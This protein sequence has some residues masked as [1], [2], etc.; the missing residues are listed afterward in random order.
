MNRYKQSMRW[1]FLSLAVLPQ[2]H[3]IDAVNV[4]IGFEAAEGYTVGEKPIDPWL[5]MGGEQHN[6]RNGSCFK[7]A[8]SQR[9]SVARNHAGFV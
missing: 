5:C 7:H 9:K 2:A 8:G 4:A 6:L 3:A 1:S